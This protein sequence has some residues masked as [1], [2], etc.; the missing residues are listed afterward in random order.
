MAAK[1]LTVMAKSYGP[2]CLI[3]DRRVG[4]ILLNYM[5]DIRILVPGYRKTNRALLTSKG[6][7]ITNYKNYVSNFLAKFEVPQLP[8]IITDT[9]KTV[10][11]MVVESG[12]PAKLEVLSQRMSHNV[13]T[14]KKYYHQ[15]Q[16]TKTSIFAKSLIRPL[17]SNTNSVANGNSFYYS[18]EQQ[19]N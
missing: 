10:A 3:L 12:N 9:R 11:T 19:S 1:T 13:T 14:S 17:V 18:T 2:V 15:R 7:D 5:K 16:K 8:T 6:T 4:R